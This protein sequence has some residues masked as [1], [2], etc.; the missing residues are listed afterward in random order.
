MYIDYSDSKGGGG[1]D[2]EDEFDRMA[3]ERDED[4]KERDA[5]AQR[6]LEKDK[7]K[8]DKR[9][10][11]VSKSD[12]KGF[13]EVGLVS[14]AST[15]YQWKLEILIFCFKIIQ[16]ARRLQQEKLD[17]EDTLDEIRKQSRRAYLKK[18]EE[19]KVQELEDDIADDE[20]LFNEEELTKDELKQREYNKKL[21]SL[22]KGEISSY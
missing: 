22:A 9:K 12:K 16:A 3:R 19:Q 17:R 6:M 5:F 2:D 11:I 7:A 1:G 15:F 18:R 13:E 8:Q 4:L 14:Q 10:G 20:F 21:L